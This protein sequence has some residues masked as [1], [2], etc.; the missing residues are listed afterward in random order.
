MTV[1]V[2]KNLNKVLFLLVVG[3]A[4]YSAVT[5][6]VIVALFGVGFYMVLI[7]LLKTRVKGVLADERQQKIGA[8]AAETSFRIIVPMLLFASLALMLGQ[9]KEEFFYIHALGLVLSYITAL[10]AI[11]YTLTYWYFDRQSGGREHD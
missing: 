4:I 7:S 11:I 6:L 9:G 3:L 8:K 5:Q 1:K 10:A 2:Y